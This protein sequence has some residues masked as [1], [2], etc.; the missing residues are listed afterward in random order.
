[1]PQGTFV[2]PHCSSLCPT[3]GIILYLNTFHTTIGCFHQ[4]YF[5]SKV[6]NRF[7]VFAQTPR[8]RLHAPKRLDLLL[9]FT[10]NVLIL[11]VGYALKCNIVLNRGGKKIKDV[12]IFSFFF[13]FY[14]IQALWKAKAMET[15]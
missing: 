8:L 14:R 15:F 6:N 7:I 12:R 9:F 11:K 1:M 2:P 3:K 4:T 13:S 10:G 5:H